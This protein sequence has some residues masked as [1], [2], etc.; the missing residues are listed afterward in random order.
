MKNRDDVLTDDASRTSNDGI[1]D[2]APL[3][4]VHHQLVD[5]DINEKSHRAHTRAKR[6]I[7]GR[8]F[9]HI[10]GCVGA[11]FLVC[12]VVQYGAYLD[13]YPRED[14]FTRTGVLM[15]DVTLKTAENPPVTD[16][17]TT[18]PANPDRSIVENDEAHANDNKPELVNASTVGLQSKRLDKHLGASTTANRSK[19]IMS[20]TRQ[21]PLQP[22]LPEVGSGKQPQVM[23]SGHQRAE[24]LDGMD[25]MKKQQSNKGS[26]PNLRSGLSTEER[27]PADELE[28]SSG[29]YK[30]THSL[31]WTFFMGAAILLAP[32]LG[33]LT[34]NYI[35]GLVFNFM[36]LDTRATPVRMHA[37][38]YDIEDTP[39][40]KLPKH[41]FSR[42]QKAMQCQPSFPKNRL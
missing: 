33:H 24:V 6:T 23:D 40:D 11:A 16:R 2:D 39:I 35:E 8:I 32:L 10:C 12:Y 42:L 38:T 31:V 26:S 19:V 22:Q 17:P 36:N 20:G 27:E 9:I 37:P 34:G 3:E 13:I 7:T 25:G 15:P 18:I 30:M 4:D 5:G 41:F 28:L 14:A 21:S 29:P 1:F